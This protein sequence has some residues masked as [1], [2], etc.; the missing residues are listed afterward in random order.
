VQPQHLARQAALAR[1]VYYLAADEVVSV[2]DVD[3]RC[4]GDRVALGIIGASPSQSPG[5]RARR[6]RAFLRP[7][8]RTNDSLVVGAGFTRI[9]RRGPTEAHSPVIVLGLYG[10]LHDNQIGAEALLVGT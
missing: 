3:R 2:T 1:E 9:E 7:I 5:W 8:H 10:S 4:A 6:H